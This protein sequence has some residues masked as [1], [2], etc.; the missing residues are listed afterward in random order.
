MLPGQ[1]LHLDHD[2]WDRSKLRGFAHSIATSEPQPRKHGEYRSQP[3]RG[4][5]NQYTAG[6][7][8]F[9][10]IANSDHPL[11]TNSE[12]TRFRLPLPRTMD[13]WRTIDID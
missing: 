7:T 12:S 13:T 9:P 8:R 6:K 11:E 1:K 5:A 10:K 2:D 4:P 3:S